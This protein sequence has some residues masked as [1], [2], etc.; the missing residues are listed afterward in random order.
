M[1]VRIPPRAWMSLCDCCV[2]SG[3]GLC[4]ELIIR[5]EESYRLWFVVV[6]DLETSWMGRPWPT[7]G[8][9]PNKNL[10]STLYCLN[11][12]SVAKFKNHTKL[13]HRAA[14]IRRPQIDNIELKNLMSDH[15]ELTGNLLRFIVGLYVGQ[16]RL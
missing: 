4:D 11:T 6:C 10:P 1:W 3:R 16:L 13:N 12:E 14:T 15:N 8:V 7:G 9:A 2:L 5:Q